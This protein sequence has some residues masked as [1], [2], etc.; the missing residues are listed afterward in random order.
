MRLNQKAP[1][2]GNV[3]NAPQGLSHQ[4]TKSAALDSMFPLEWRFHRVFSNRCVF[5][6]LAP[7]GDRPSRL[8]HF[9]LFRLPRR[10]VFGVGS[11]VAHDFPSQLAT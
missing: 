8:N 6:W 10:W 11:C 5:C 1:R 3:G 9:Q 7:D 4:G 2:Q